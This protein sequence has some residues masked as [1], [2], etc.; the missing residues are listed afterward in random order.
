MHFYVVVIQDPDDGREISLQ[1]ALAHARAAEAR[2]RY[3][4]LFL[5]F[6]TQMT[7]A[8]ILSLFGVGAARMVVALLVVGC[9]FT[10]VWGALS[11]ICASDLRDV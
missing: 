6:L 8:F 2:L 9:L 3:R 5:L 11:F 1:E 4:Q 7:V 10:L